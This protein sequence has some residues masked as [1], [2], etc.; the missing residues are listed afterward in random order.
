MFLRVKLLCSAL[1]SEKYK[2]E[3]KNKSYLMNIA[4]IYIIRVLNSNDY[5]IGSASNLFIR[6]LQHPDKGRVS[7]KQKGSIN[8][9]SLIRNTD[10]SNISFEVLQHS[11]NF[12]YKFKEL[13]PNVI[14]NTSR[15]RD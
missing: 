2:P 14:L 10:H 5:Y 8:L 11:T 4:G 13:H 9:Y 1:F 12:L 6:L 7:S 3:S 15:R